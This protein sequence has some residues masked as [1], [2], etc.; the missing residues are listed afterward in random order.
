MAFVPDGMYF[1]DSEEED[2]LDFGDSPPAMRD[3]PPEPT[4]ASVVTTGKDHGTAAAT[5]ARWTPKE[6]TPDSRTG[7]LQYAEYLIIMI[8]AA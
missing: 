8:G 4:L 5:T 7:D 6:I 3:L 1:G 2:E